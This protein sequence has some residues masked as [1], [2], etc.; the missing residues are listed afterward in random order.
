MENPGWAWWN[1]PLIPEL[2]RRGRWISVSLKSA[3]STKQVLG[4]PWS[5]TMRNA[6]LKKPKTKQY[7]QS[8]QKQT[9]KKS[10]QLSFSP[11]TLFMNRFFPWHCL[12]LSSSLFNN[13]TCSLF[14]SFTLHGLSGPS[15]WKLPEGRELSPSRSWKNL[16]QPEKC[17]PRYNF[18]AS[19]T[20]LKHHWFILS[21]TCLKI[22]QVRERWGCGWGRKGD[23][24]P[25]A[26]NVG[27]RRVRCGLC[28]QFCTIT[29][30]LE[31]L[32]HN[33]AISSASHSSP[34]CTLHPDTRPVSLEDSRCPLIFSSSHPP[35]EMGFACPWYRTWSHSFQSFALTD[36]TKRNLRISF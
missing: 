6:V 17:Q 7:K 12:A 4:Q 5:V 31:N 35:K 27:L 22:R 15:E 10:L 30:H 14:H 25:T 20:C 18:R 29:A 19:V 28:L 1:M 8:K 34:F 9:T 16:Q 24:Y 26:G 13:I 23:R 21:G 32:K 11:N 2:G 33:F 36:M 3:W